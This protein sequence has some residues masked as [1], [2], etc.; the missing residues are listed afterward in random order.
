LVLFRANRKKFVSQSSSST[1]IR[2]QEEIQKAVPIRQLK[3]LRVSCST[4]GSIF[5]PNTE[6][7]SIEVIPEGISALLKILPTN[8][9]YLIT[10]VQSDEQ[11]RETMKILEESGILWAGLNPNK[12]LFCSTD[13]GRAHM[14]RQLGV[15][16][17]IDNDFQVLK[18][19]RSFV[20]QLVHITP[21]AEHLT[22]IKELNISR[23]TNLSQYVSSFDKSKD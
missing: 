11:E 10:K 3:G 17:H 21:T 23:A 16:L 22:Y 19:L 14:G 1:S 2:S 12:I 8:D 6:G 9:I 5:V 13:E 7:Q 18:M 4:I 20:P 15:H